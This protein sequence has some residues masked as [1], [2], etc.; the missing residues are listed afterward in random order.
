MRF[1]SGSPTLPAGG[2]RRLQ[3]R[4]TV[5]RKEAEAPLKPDDYLPSVMTC[6]NYLKLPV[7]KCLPSWGRMPEAPGEVVYLLILQK[8][9]SSR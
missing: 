6:A 7:S 2:L 8:T 5:V 1:I 3:P 4:L 9:W